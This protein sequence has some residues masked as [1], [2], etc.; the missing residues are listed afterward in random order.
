MGNADKENVLTQELETLT[1]IVSEIKS[2]GYS[3]G[4]VSRLIIK[5]YSCLN[6]A[7]ELRTEMDK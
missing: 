3:L 6:K 4:R 5:L 2:H 7:N 1:D